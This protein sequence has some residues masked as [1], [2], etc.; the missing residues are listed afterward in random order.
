[1]LNIYLTR[2]GQDED[3]AKK[4]LNGRRDTPL[5]TQ[6]IRQA[7]KLS[8]KIKEI[9]ICFE[10]VY[11]SPLQRA[12]KTAEII[13]KEIGCDKP[14]KIEDLIERDFGI[15]T[16][17]SLNQINEFCSSDILKTETINYFLSPEKGETFPQIIERAKKILKY[18]DKKHKNTNILLVTHGDLGKMLYCS[19][20][21]LNWKEVL[22]MFHFGNSDLLLMSP[23]SKA[24]DV[25]VFRNKQ[26][27]S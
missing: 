18:L 26:Y 23:N 5:T 13:A 4:I 17:K 16:G 9:G 22:K 12:Y 19:Y 21:N 27:N 15:M 11:T 8:Q 10:K 2:H 1:M 25:C 24:E 14:E 7:K 20:Y 3:N 6:G